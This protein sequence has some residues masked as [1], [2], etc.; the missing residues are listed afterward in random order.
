MVSPLTQ[1]LSLNT[2]LFCLQTSS[3]GTA[4][5]VIRRPL[6]VSRRVRISVLMLPPPVVL[7]LG[8]ETPWSAR[9]G[10]VGT[11]VD[12]RNSTNVYFLKTKSRCG[13]APNIEEGLGIYPNKINSFIQNSGKVC[14]SKKYKN[15]MEIY[16]SKLTFYRK[17]KW[18]VRSI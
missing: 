6:W 15:L 1:P 17:P 11:S 13:V 18:S 7:L 9:T 14:F 16:L 2:Y 8:P 5:P 10:G 3:T 12:S 4:L